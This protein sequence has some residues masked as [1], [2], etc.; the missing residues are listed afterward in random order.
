M[1][2]ISKGITIVIMISLIITACEKNIDGKK[3]LES[4]NKNET[5][6]NKFY[7]A[8][9]EAPFNFE[10]KEVFEEIHQNIKDG[11]PLEFS[12]KLATIILSDNQLQISE[13]ELTPTP[14][15]T[16]KDTKFYNWNG[17]IL[18]IN[19]GALSKKLGMIQSQGFIL[20][21]YNKKIYYGEFWS[22]ISS[23]IPDKRI[24]TFF[25]DGLE[26]QDDFLELFD[27]NHKYE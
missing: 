27:I 3:Q 2:L 6:G 16:E 1:N 18:K 24:K 21:I 22:V 25:L 17:S 10:N 9:N 13:D 26:F 5:T 23:Q 11:K 15:I 20:R 7:E 4:T 14:I 8:L 19:R 12:I